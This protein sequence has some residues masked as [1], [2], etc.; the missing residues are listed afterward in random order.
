LRSFRQKKGLLSRLTQLFQHLFLVLSTNFELYRAKASP[1]NSLI[2]AC[3]CLKLDN[4]LAVVL[5][6]HLLA[7]GE[8]RSDFELRVN[9]IEF[10][11]V[12]GFGPLRFSLNTVKLL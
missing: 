5:S 3:L 2:M 8:Q 10:D 7:T 4:M 6:G 11:L 12:S 9:D 1:A